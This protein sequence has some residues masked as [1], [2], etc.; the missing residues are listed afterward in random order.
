MRGIYSP[1]GQTGVHISYYWTRPNIKATLFVRGV[2][3]SGVGNWYR[4]P[5]AI[6]TPRRPVV[7]AWVIRSPR[8]IIAIPERQAPVV[9]TRFRLSQARAR[10]DQRLPAFTVE[11]PLH[12]RCRKWVQ[13]DRYHPRG[14]GRMQ[15]TLVE[16]IADRSCCVEGAQSIVERGADVPRRRQHQLGRGGHEHREGQALPAISW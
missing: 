1:K 7:V 10:Q 4:Y 15:R 2:D 6:L 16:P 3:P 11:G 13:H 5:Q 8:V 12:K 14:L 9:G